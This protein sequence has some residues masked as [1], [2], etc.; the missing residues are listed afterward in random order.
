MSNE[1]PPPVPAPPVLQATG[2]DAGLSL[3]YANEIIDLTGVRSRAKKVGDRV[4]E[5]RVC[6]A[7]RLP[8]SL[9]P[10]W[11]RGHLVIVFFRGGT[12]TSCDLQ[13]QRWRAH[14]DRL[15]WNGAAIVA[16]TPQAPEDFAAE[17]GNDPGDIAIF[18]DTRG[19]AAAAFD[20][21][22]MVPPEIV[23]VIAASGLDAPVLGAHGQWMLP[24]P[25]VFVVGRCGR[26]RFAHV[27]DDPHDP[28]DPTQAIVA[29]ER[30]LA[31]AAQAAR[32]TVRVAGVVARA[33]HRGHAS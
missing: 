23:D 24:V 21:A 9:E 10:H 2:S 1:A 5:F 18:S 28:L 12:C 7:R 25:A 33:A 6:D 32:D 26:I 20:L 17:F 19:E 3:P 15:A 31:D 27:E 13:L 11:R 14:L 4:G 22:V 30:D 29:L 8:I 16:I